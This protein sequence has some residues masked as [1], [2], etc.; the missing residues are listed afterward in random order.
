MNSD[1][2]STPRARVACYPG[3]KKSFEKL[4]ISFNSAGFH[5]AK[6]DAATP[7]DIGLIDLRKSLVSTRKAKTIAAVLRRKSPES[8]VIFLVSHDMENQAQ[9]SLRRFGEVILAGENTDHVL[10]RCKEII[11]LRNLAEETGERLKSLAA[12]SRL[13]DFPLVITSKNPARILI[14]GQPGPSAIA[15]INAVTQIAEECVCVLTAGQA[16]RAMEHYYFDC[17]IFLPVSENDPLLAFGKTLRR[18][19]RFGSMAIIQLADS[20]EDFPV[21]ARKGA[22]EFMLTE[23]IPSELKAKT[24]LSARR[25]R[26]QKS[27]RQFLRSCTGDTIRDASSGAFT[28]LFLTEHGNRLCAR[29]D[30]TG[31]PLSLTLI[32]FTDQD[33]SMLSG[34]MLS[35]AARL[36]NRITRAED[37]VAR[38]AR[39]KFA[40]LSAATQAVDAEKIGRR[41]SGVLSSTAFRSKKNQTPYSAM[42]DT[43][44]T[45]REEGASIE[46]TVAAAIKQMRT[47]SVLTPRQRSPQ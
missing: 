11:R 29:T 22:R 24:Q 10:V 37:L 44:T 41:I 18:H 39:N 40:I 30:H 13:A 8:S 34:E 36:I 7:A 15:A 16:M 33:R 1:L 45:R 42:I 12:L 26:L 19:P 3:D 38:I 4:T 28:S 6:P 20:M 23:Q 27:M 46:E 2:L 25:A 9:A 14:A 5:I 43:I 47:E 32:K 31:R 21:Y 35:Q 17:A